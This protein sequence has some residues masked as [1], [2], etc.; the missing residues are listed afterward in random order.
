MALLCR[1]SLA[2][3][4][5][6]STPLLFACRHARALSGASPPP[7][8]SSPPPPPPP[9]PSPDASFIERVKLRGANALLGSYTATRGF[10]RV[11]DG[12]V[13]TR[14]GAGEV[15]ATLTVTPA[16]LNSYGTLHGGATCTLVDVLGTMALLAH[17]PLHPGVSVELGVSFTRA[18]RAGEKITLLGRVLKT[19][20]ALGFTQVDIMRADGSLIASGRHTKAL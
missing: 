16:L 1:T 14:L 18:A 20:K 13:V 3:R 7:P 4:S 9:P 12:L 10:D 8:P 6:W 19:G 2:L 11:C 5:S 15:E 17:D